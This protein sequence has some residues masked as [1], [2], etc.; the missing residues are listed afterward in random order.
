MESILLSL[1]AC[2]AWGGSEF[3]GGMKSKNVPPLMILFVVNISGFLIM[4]L[5]LLLFGE[6]MLDAEHFRYAAVAGVV[7]IIGWWCVFRAMS[8]GSIGVISL[9]CSTSALVPIIFDIMAGHRLSVLQYAGMML[10][11]AGVI[12][13]SV[14]NLSSD[15]KKRLTA[16]AWF[17]FL[18]TFLI[19]LYY[20]FID[21]AGNQDPY[22]GIFIA[23]CVSTIM[24]LSC[25]IY[26]RAKY[27][28]NFSDFSVLFLVGAMDGTGCIAF[29]VATTMALVSVV[30][31]VSSLYP[32]VVMMLA[33]IFLRERM[34]TFQKVGAVIAVG[35]VILISGG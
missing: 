34:G 6:E 19:G 4:G 28:F 13:L 12:F 18:G 29:G 2:L 14:E 30:T 22:W 8:V 3:L 25:F 1:Y 24:V 32:I 27:K 10:A 21:L 33:W 17:A 20:I 23:K 35:G 7:G 16:G 5:A 31:V 15:K 11:F 26:R 9:I